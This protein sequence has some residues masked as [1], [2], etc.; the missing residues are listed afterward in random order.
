M[1]YNLALD[2]S[3]PQLNKKRAALIGC[4]NAKDCCLNSGPFTV[5]LTELTLPIPVFLIELTSPIC[6][7]LFD[8]YEVSAQ[9]LLFGM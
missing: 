1:N 8:H 2:L 4:A 5:F 9:D 3:L 6:I 7:H